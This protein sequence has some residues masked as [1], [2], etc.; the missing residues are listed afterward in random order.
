MFL[1]SRTCDTRPG[2]PVDC[3]G[4]TLGKSPRGRDE[5]T[6]PVMIA[7]AAVRLL[8]GATGLWGGLGLT[9]DPRSSG[10]EVNVQGLK[11]GM[12]RFA[13]TAVYP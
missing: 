5:V 13:A 3:C 9:L 11:I 10:K 2:S 6:A 7:G 8:A 1:R 12:S 4:V